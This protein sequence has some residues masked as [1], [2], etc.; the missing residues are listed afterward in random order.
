MT[1]REVLEWYL[2]SGVDEAIGEVPVDRFAG[3]VEARARVIEMAALPSTAPC[4]GG[5]AEAPATESLDP[6]AP[7]TASP[8][9]AP[10]PSLSADA[11]VQ[12]AVAHASQATTIAELKD[13][14][15]RFDGCPLKKT[16]MNLVFG[17][18]N[19]ES[20][21]LFIGEAPGAEEDRQGRP[22]VGVSGQLLDR[23]L[24][25]IG[26]DRSKVFISN[27][28][29][30]RP[31]GNRAP[32]TTEIAACMPFVERLVELIDPEVLVALGGAAAKALLSQTEGVSKLRGRW[33]TYATPRFS[34]P[35]PATAMYHPA[36]LLR[37]PE[38]KRAAWLDLLGLKNKIQTP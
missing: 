26:L 2:E 17:D 37:S 14:L 25:S 1:P 38:Q 34:R 30:W 32:T 23:M 16:A 35:I 21:I 15:A 28:V 12:T 18:G 31:P 11:A 27:T 20:R 3:A 22:F 10:S 24:A 19:P 9:P 8:R 33:F 5:L 36:Y 29:F 4:A 6:A 7:A 13:A